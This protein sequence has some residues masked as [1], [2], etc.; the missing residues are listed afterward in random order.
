MV[1]VFDSWNPRS[2][3]ACAPLPGRSGAPAPRH[4]RPSSAAGRRCPAPQTRCKTTQSDARPPPTS[5]AV[6]DRDDRRSYPSTPL[7][8]THGSSSSAPFPWSLTTTVF[9]Q[10]STRRGLA[11]APEDRRW[12]ASNPPSIAQHRLC[13]GS[14]TR[15]LLG[16]RDAHM[17]SHS[18]MLS[19][20]FVQNASRRTL[21][22]IRRWL[23]SG[24][25]SGGHGGSCTS[26]S[27]RSIVASAS[28]SV[29]KTVQP[30]FIPT[31]IVVTEQVVVFAYD[32]DAHFG[33]LSSG[34][35]WWWAVADAS[36]M[37]TDIATRPRLLR[38][39][40]AARGRRTASRVARRAAARC[41][42]QRLMLDR[43][44]GLTK[45]YNRVHDPQR[46]LS[47]DIVELR[48]IHVEL[49]HAVRDAYGW[50]DLDL[51]HDFHETKFGTRFHPRAGAAPGGPRPA[52]RAQPRA[53]RR[54]GP[55]GLHGKTKSTGKRKRRCRGS[56]DAWIRRCLSRGSPRRRDSC[57]TRSSS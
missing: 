28:R 41:I 53:L 38:N 18:S 25:S 43:Q 3:A 6:L 46:S 12:R 55:T 48:E 24:G 4:G 20:T 37:R 42:A 7:T 16:V 15:L 50:D 31:D 49:D 10:R 40:P 45:T 21:G 1:P 13:E 34:F 17:H 57:A 23:V 8:V 35:H 14:S 27:P 54:G 33:L 9:S 47:D 39:L 30:M 44:E 26:G 36:T 5:E 2:A 56:D 51:G 11:P 29:S 19:V 32:D 22:S 52:A